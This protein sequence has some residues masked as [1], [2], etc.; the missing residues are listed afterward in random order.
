MVISSV[1]K[2]LILGRISVFLFSESLLVVNG[3]E[4]S[5]VCSQ[6]V[7]AATAPMFRLISKQIMYDDDIH[8]P[9]S[10]ITCLLLLSCRP[11]KRTI[12]CNVLLSRL[13]VYTI[14]TPAS[15]I[16]WNSISEW[17]LAFMPTANGSQTTCDRWTSLFSKRFPLLAVCNSSP[18]GPRDLRLFSKPK[19]RAGKPGKS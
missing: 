9:L 13:D 11:I 2:P 14:Y 16:S 10:I 4:R 12:N 3:Q 6:V 5:L 7:P 8:T 18:L 15:P 19:V 17:S 1:T